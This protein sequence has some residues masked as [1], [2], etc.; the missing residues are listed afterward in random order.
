MIPR[1]E[2]KVNRSLEVKNYYDAINAPSYSHEF[3]KCFGM[4]FVK[5]IKDKPLNEV[6]NIIKEMVEKDFKERQNKIKCHIIKVKKVWKPI[7][8]KFFIKLEKITKRPFKLKYIKVYIT[9]LSRCN[10]NFKRGWFKLSLCFDPKYS[11]TVIAHE[12]FHFQFQ[13]YYW[14]K[15]KKELNENKT[16]D[17]KEALTVLLNEEFKDFLLIEDKGY[18]VHQKLRKHLSKVWRKTKDF[19]RLIDGGVEFLK[20]NY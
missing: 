20:R 18:L 1:I 3:S 5:K 15:C 8:K 2:F 4:E 9:P 16:H 19:D 12:L 11:A 7:H 14:N 13:W 10:Y 17:L 6:K